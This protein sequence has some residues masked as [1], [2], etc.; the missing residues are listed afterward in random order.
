MYKK[1]IL[2]GIFLMA[3]LGVV[4]AQEYEVDGFTVALWHMNE[5]SGLVVDDES[6][7]EN[8]GVVDGAAWTS[9][10]KFGNALDFDGVDDKVNVPYSQSIGELDEITLEAWVKRDSL[11]DGMVISKNGPY[12]LSVRNNVVEGGVYA[13][14]GWTHVSGITE[15]EV[16]VWYNIALTYD[17]SFVKVY[18][19]GVEDGSVSKTGDV[20]VTGQ[21][22]HI[23]WGEPG[24][25]QY[26]N[27][28]I[29]EV[30][31]S[32]VAREFLPDPSQT[33]EERIE[34]LEEKVE[35]LENRTTVLE[36]LMDKI[37]N[38]IGRLPRGLNE[39]WN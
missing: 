24:H 3:V 30:R 27:G 14:S 7:N 34:A 16:D 26:F 20:L 6:V 35:E 37:V 8:D 5:G 21:G 13:G 25:D 18:L 4:G 1:L 23:G 12:F 33:L 39:H 29:D 19:N 38:F 11:V 32:N 10:G 17:G 2:T 9:E 28:V 36:R 15:L 31:I 22:L